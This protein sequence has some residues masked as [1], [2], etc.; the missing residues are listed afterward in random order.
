MV[1]QAD[2]EWGQMYGERL[3][4][5]KPGQPAHPEDEYSHESVAEKLAYL[6]QQLGKN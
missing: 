4:F 2:W 6:K 5:Q 3:Y 1:Q